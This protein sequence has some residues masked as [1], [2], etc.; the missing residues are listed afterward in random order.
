MENALNNIQ[1]DAAPGDFG[2]LI[3]GAEAG[4]EHKIEG[5]TIAKVSRF[6][7]AHQSLFDGFGLDARKIHP[8]PIVADFD[9]YLVPLVVSGEFQG[10][11]GRLAGAGAIFVRFD[12]VPD[13]I[14]NQVGERF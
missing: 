7:S 5:V 2:D 9:D 10:S 13:R 3:G 1:P 4:P 14:A 6:F 11:L 12:S 8:A